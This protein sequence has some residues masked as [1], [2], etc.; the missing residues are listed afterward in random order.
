MGELYKVQL[1]PVLT[2]QSVAQFSER[3]HVQLVTPQALI[4]GPCELFSLDLLTVTRA[5]LSPIRVSFEL[6]VDS[7][8]KRCW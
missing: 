8:L 5:E 2:K 1:G 6:A 4:S 3:A 7:G